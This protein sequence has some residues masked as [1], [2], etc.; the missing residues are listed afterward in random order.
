MRIRRASQTLESQKTLGF[1]S[2]NANLQNQSNARITENAGFPQRKREIVGPAKRSKHRKHYGTAVRMRILRASQTPES[3]KTLRNRSENANSEGEPNARITENTTEPQRE[4]EF[5]RPAKRSNQRKHYGTAA[6]MRILRASQTP[7]AQK[8]RWNHSE[9][10]KFD[11]QPH[12]R[13]A[14]NATEPQ[15]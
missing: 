15:R 12:A 8:I 13:I 1:H 2:E 10:A 3:Q 14:E 5:R 11:G 7:E 4:C 9:N 6:K